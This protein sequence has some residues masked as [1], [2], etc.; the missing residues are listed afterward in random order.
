MPSWLAHGSLLIL[1]GGLLAA[2]FGVPLPEDPILL[3][4]GALARRGS[5][6]ALPSTFASVYVA[7]IIADC[8]LYWLSRI[9]GEA[10]FSHRPIKWLATDSRRARARVFLQQ[11]GPQAIF[12][13]RHVAG[14]RS[15]LFVLAGTER[16]PFRIF[17]LFDMLAAM[18]SVPVVFGLGYFFSAHLQR[19]EEGLA[20]AEHWLLLLAGVL[21][22]A[23]IVLWRI[24]GNPIPACFESGTADRDD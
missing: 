4:A 22:T 18:I 24:R 2:G 1:V 11:H 16:M 5:N 6:L 12:W 20:R 9:F 13:G 14:L 3:A 23:G 21:L 7:A 17:L 10:L 15:L 8:G 19:V